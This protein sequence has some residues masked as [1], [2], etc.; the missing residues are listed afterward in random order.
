LGSKWSRVRPQRTFF[1][2]SLG[3]WIWQ[4]SSGGRYW[5][6]VLLNTSSTQS[7]KDVTSYKT[8]YMYHRKMRSTSAS[9]Q[10]WLNSTYNH[11]LP[12]VCL[13]LSSYCYVHLSHTRIYSTQHSRM[14]HI[15]SILSCAHRRSYST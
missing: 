7:A 15:P 1:L 8:W 4:L 9:T 11:L 5:I 6:T 10:P 2:S 12:K 14:L 3:T 13:N